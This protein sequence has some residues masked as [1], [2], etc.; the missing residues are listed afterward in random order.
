MK[1]RH[2]GVS[3]YSDLAEEDISFLCDG[4]KVCDDALHETMP[5]QNGE[6]CFFSAEGF[7]CQNPA[8]KLK[9]IQAV[10]KRIAQIEKQLLEGDDHGLV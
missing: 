4:D 2:C 8:S 1:R 3:I 6:R 7:V 9:A 10:K 5:R